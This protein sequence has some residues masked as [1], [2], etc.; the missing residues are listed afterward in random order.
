MLHRKIISPR[1]VSLEMYE[2]S[3]RKD[4]A[5]V[6]MY[7][8]SGSDKRWTEF[9][10]PA[11]VKL[12]RVV[13]DDAVVRNYSSRIDPNAD[14]FINR[15]ATQRCAM[16]H[17][18]IWDLIAANPECEHQ[19]CMVSEDDA[20]YPNV[21]VHDW[22]RQVFLR[23]WDPRPLFDIKANADA[24]VVYLRRCIGRNN[25]TNVTSCAKL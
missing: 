14:D 12:I 6:P 22:R 24:D 20:F 21:P 4:R 25:S 3:V 9:Q 11:G 2:H 10:A 15:Q 23:P 8:L 19:K 5:L 1:V 16:G 7:V 13:V 17:M 18:H